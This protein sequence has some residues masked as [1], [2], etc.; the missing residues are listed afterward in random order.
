[1]QASTQKLSDVDSDDEDEDDDRARS[2]RVDAA[3]QASAGVTF[4]AVSA[5]PLLDPAAGMA[6]QQP[7]AQSTTSTAKGAPMQPPSQQTPPQAGFLS[8]HLSRL[9]TGLGLGRGSVFM[10]GGFSF[11]SGASAGVATLQRRIVTSHTGHVA[12]MLPFLLWMVLVCAIDGVGFMSLRNVGGDV[13]TY[14]I[15][16]FVIVG[17]VWAAL[18]AEADITPRV[19]RHGSPASHLM[20]QLPFC[21]TVCCVQVPALFLLCPRAGGRARRLARD[22]HVQA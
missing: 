15:I 19:M 6:Q 11:A 8:S 17:C 9:S 12:F 3:A 21:S 16:N 20:D 14:G 18:D 4:G 22:R 7:G 5:Q 13:A 10:H 1:M 2:P